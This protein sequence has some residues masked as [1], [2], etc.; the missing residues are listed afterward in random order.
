MSFKPLS[1]QDQPSQAAPPVALP[2]TQYILKLPKTSQ[3]NPTSATALVESLLGYVERDITLVI[4]GDGAAITWQII[5]TG[6]I[7]GES[8]SIISAI[9]RLY[10]ECEIETKPHTE[11]AFVNP[12]M[13]YTIPIKQ[14][15]PVF[16]PIKY[17]EEL[18][19]SDPLCLLANAL[20]S[21]EVG[22]RVRYVVHI[23]EQDIEAYKRELK[24]ITTSGVSAA[25]IA[26]GTGKV[27]GSIFDNRSALGWTVPLMVGALQIGGEV[28]KGVQERSNPE[29]KPPKFVS[30]EQEIFWHKIA[31]PLFHAYLFVQVDVPTVERGLTFGTV[32][33]SVAAFKNYQVLSFADYPFNKG[34]EIKSQA[35]AERTSIISWII[36]DVEKRTKTRQKGKPPAIT[37]YTN[38]FNYAELGSLW[39]LPNER[40]TTPRI[41]WAKT[42]VSLPPVMV[43]KREGVQ[44]GTN[45]Y[46]G[47]D[48]PVYLPY[49]SRATHHYI[50]GKT[51]MGK[52][53]YL[54]R[55]I[56]QDIANGYGV[57]VIDPHGELARDILRWSIP[58]EREA[59]VVFLDLAHEEHPIPLNMLSNP[60]SLDVE[61]AVSQVHDVIE[62]Y[63]DLRDTQ[64][65]PLLLGCLM[66]LRYEK[67]P[68]LLDIYRLLNDEAYRMQLR[69]LAHDNL[70]VQMNWDTF[71]ARPENIKSNLATTLSERI[72]RFYLKDGLRFMTCHPDS[73]DLPAYIA[74]GKIIILSLG[75]PKGAWTEA[76]QR[77][78]G[79]ILVGQIRMAALSRRF[80]PAKP[81]F[82]YIDEVQNFISTPLDK[83]LS[84]A[85]KFGLSLSVA[86]QYL[87]Q[88]EG[89]ILKALKGNVGTLTVFRVG[90]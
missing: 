14:T 36:E 58:E 22:E 76:H 18:K 64:V 10:P 55:L 78:L 45:R 70:A 25:N 15:A 79:G 62:R 61:T 12:F 63:G 71:E 87:D 72:T 69:E 48:E 2:P 26:S 66:L 8:A 47:R 6:D 60:V 65:R 67:N 35:Q 7:G 11:P 21:V 68:T 1:K 57:A 52:S 88:V 53:T 51:R 84:E 38:I 24:S 13:R 27:V 85:G 49:S 34:V 33:Q 83:V 37:Q 82:L 17:P 30:H 80:H 29:R 54:H 46:G 89:D 31:A 44:L 90:E 42:N 39:H 77:L 16:T 43:G 32:L 41:A 3:W 74:A 4:E 28:M 9:K 19:D 50:L 56:H 40:F 59:D 73:L 86:H 75:D 81:Y 20:N 5:D 23:T